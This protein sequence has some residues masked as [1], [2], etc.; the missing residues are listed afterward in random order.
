M[1]DKILILG[2][3]GSGKTTLGKKL[4]RI[5]K[6]KS[7]S[8][9]QFRYSKDFQKRFSEERSN[10]YMTQFIK[11]KRW[12]LDGIYTK[13]FIYPAFRKADIIISIT[14][15]RINLAYRI[16][17]R[18]IRER[19]KYKNRPVKDLIKLLYWSQKYKRHNEKAHISLAKKYKKEIIFLKNN[20]DIDNFLN[21]ISS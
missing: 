19:Q 2:T 13:P 3:S 6:I 21:S 14:T 5:L 8:I 15:T 11:Q 4:S 20:K 10:R 16:I 1:Y 18:E 12:I 9:D 7:K 17:K